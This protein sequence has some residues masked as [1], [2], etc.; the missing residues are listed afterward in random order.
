MSLQFR[1]D[2]SHDMVHLLRSALNRRMGH[3]GDRLNVQM[4]GND[5]VISG[6]VSSYSQKQWAQ[7]SI[8]QLV[9][10]GKIRNE[11]RVLPGMC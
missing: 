10:D 5:V 4:Q 9:R 3:V 2:S 6:Y 11:L 8:R 7:E 1:R